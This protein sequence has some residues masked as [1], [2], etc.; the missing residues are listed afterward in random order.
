VR[1]TILGG[2]GF[3]VPLVY[4]ALLRDT[5]TRRVEEVVL[6]DVDAARLDAVTHVLR[7]MAYG[8]PAAPRVVT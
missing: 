6:Y 4:G 5:S 7:Q 8:D 1:L 2:G 3:R